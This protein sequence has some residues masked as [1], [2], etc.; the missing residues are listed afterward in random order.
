MKNILYISILISIFFL[1]AC[2]RKH[3]CE[4]EKRY[5]FLNED[6]KW[7]QLADTAPTYKITTKYSG[8]HIDTVKVAHYVT[9]E[10]YDKTTEWCGSVLYSCY[11]VYITFPLYNG[12]DMSPLE[13]RFENTKKGG[14]MQVHFGG[15]EYLYSDTKLDTAMI[16]GKI[17]ENV[18]KS[19]AGNYYAKGIGWIYFKNNNN[20]TAEII[21]SK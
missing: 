8:F 18:Y 4:D 14:G 6:M 7:V 9:H 21:P 12:R 1:N 13:L 17:Y 15:D 3:D 10:E 19:R 20:E 2:N 11:S 16:N 5:P